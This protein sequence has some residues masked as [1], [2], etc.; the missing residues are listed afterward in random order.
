MGTF[1]LIHGAGDSGWYWHLVASELRSNGHDAVTPDL[2]ADDDTARLD[3]YA[4]AVVAAVGDRTEVVVVGHRGGPLCCAQPSD[5]AGGH[6]AAV[7]P[8]LNINA[9][10]ATSGARTAGSDPPDQPVSSRE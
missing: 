6:P 4:D 3:D 9:Q 1:V 5:G 2:P 7:R 10:G 8:A